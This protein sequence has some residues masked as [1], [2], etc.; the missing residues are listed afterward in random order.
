MTLRL[1][2]DDLASIYAHGE[3]AYVEECCGM[4]IGPAPEGGADVV[5]SEI[6]AA[7][8]ER[9]DSRHNRYVISP[10]ALLKTQRSARERG[11]E[12]L[13][14]YHSHP[15]HPARPSDFDREHAWPGTSYLIISVMKGSVV[16]GRSWR[17]ADDRSRFEE[18]DLVGS[19]GVRVAFDS[20]SSE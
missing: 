20:C 15:D 16:D 5:I 19:K 13:G 11:L 6:V 4:L 17:L 14:Y 7:E 2:D 1:S 9:Q 8:N 12:I 3:R 10:Q 18:E